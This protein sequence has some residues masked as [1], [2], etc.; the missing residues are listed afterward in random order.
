[1]NHERM[2]ILE[3]LSEGKINPADAER[4]LEKISRSREEPHRPEEP[5]VSA[6]VIHLGPNLDEDGMPTPP[7]PPAPR[8]PLRFLRIMINSRKKDVINIR[9]P[10][11]LVR[12][13]LKLSTMIPEEAREKL[14]AKG[15]DIGALSGLQG[16]ELIEALRELKVD[17]DSGDGDVVRVFCE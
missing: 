1:M 17:V 2:Q 3:M 10:I 9:I 14:K 13:G 15:V 11:D 4:L 8:R 5:R 7:E 6:S 12:T 16:E